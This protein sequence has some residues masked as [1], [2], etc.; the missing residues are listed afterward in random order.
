MS[1]AL[2]GGRGRGVGGSGGRGGYGPCTAN[3]PP[4][5]V[6]NSGLYLLNRDSVTRCHRRVTFSGLGFPLYISLHCLVDCSRR[7]SA[8]A[9]ET[10]WNNMVGRA[11]RVV[12]TTTTT[13]GEGGS[14]SIWIWD[15]RKERGEGWKR[16][17]TRAHVH[18]KADQ[19]RAYAGFRTSSFLNPIPPSPPPFSGQTDACTRSLHLHISAYHFAEEHPSFRVC[20]GFR[21][22]VD[23]RR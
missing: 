20:V 23:S 21:C 2:V 4:A 1:F 17:K 19:T 10:V 5:N 7:Y 15:R 8:M 11:S 14:C 12:T 22:D 3:L 9:C 16:F 13:K 6:V 18:Q